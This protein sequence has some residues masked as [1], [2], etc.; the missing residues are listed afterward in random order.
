MMRLRTGFILSN[1]LL[2][3]MG[4]YCLALS[5][6]VTFAII[7]TILAALTLCFF[8]EIRKAI[9]IEPPHSILNSKWALLTLPFLY[10]GFDLPLLDLV[11]WFLVFLI[12]TRFVF[13][14]EL[15][16]YLFGHLLSIVCLLI[17]AIYVQELAFGIVFLMFYLVLCWG[18]IFY[19]MILE[20]TGSR[21]PPQEFI[22]AGE[23]ET[24][25]TPLFALSSGLVLLSLFMT[26]I[27][28]ISFPRLGLG[29]LTLSN[30][31]S[32][33]SG[34]TDTVKLGD[35]GKI[36][37]N[38]SVVMRI[39]YTRDG[40]PYR[41]SSRVLWR[42][43]A[44]DHFDGTRWSTTAGVEWQVD[45]QRGSDVQ[46]FH[47]SPP[48]EVVRQDV[49]M[50]FLNSEVLF[51][52]GIPLS[53]GGS[54]KGLQMDRSFSL[55][56]I[57]PGPGPKRFNILS[58]IAHPTTTYDLKTPFVGNDGF[59]SLYLQLPPMSP[60]MHALVKS[61]TAN[62]DTSLA[63]AL[64]ILGYLGDGFSYSLNL[65]E[66]PDQSALDHFL[67]TRKQ[68]HC[69]YFAAA[70]TVLLRMAD[71]PARMINGFVGDEWNDVGNYMVVRQ[72]H[73][74]SWVEAYLPEKGWMIFDPT[75]PDPGGEPSISNPLS[76]T[77]DLLRLN[78]QRYVI[79]YSFNDQV[80][81][82]NFFRTGGQ[83]ALQK[84]KVWESFN[85]GNI[86]AF[87]H[88]YVWA[89]LLL[90]GIT[91]GLILKT[92][93]GWL[94]FR[95]TPHPSIPAVMYLRLLRK[96]GKIGFHKKASST[97]REFL[98]Q[99]NDLSEEKQLLAL[100]VTHWY[101]QCRFGK[102]PVSQQEWREIDQL[103]REL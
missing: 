80:Q 59:P 1:Y 60:R 73:A 82:L 98:S 57:N 94:G 10:I 26:A 103:L 20:R 63:R 84:I 5:E 27:I 70:M 93:S 14:T 17:G 25:S 36:K 87:I 76:Q 95:W 4:I 74:H 96:L 50:E 79:R 37:L 89:L 67:F 2:A 47:S 71:I 35:V 90:T 83:T 62:S 40:L 72:K 18:L 38:E 3:G 101:E 75:P 77:L 66:A 45:H 49:Y 6:V 15:N 100:K 99:L 54:F 81:I 78:W 30:D 46:I 7:L 21:C 28:F 56:T 97:P 43:V 39:K 55:K 24:V 86:R 23:K 9:P 42:G 69:E 48:Q 41:P 53:I 61:I 88:K 34:F 12:L 51:T 31:S 52:H 85:L 92:R 33:I 29:F 16:D 8:L 64:S 68:G 58:E 22:S 13:K 32:P 44:L 102:R 91:I 65:E 11:T 19:N